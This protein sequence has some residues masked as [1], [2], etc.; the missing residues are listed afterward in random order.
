[1]RKIIECITQIH[2]INI[3]KMCRIKRG[4]YTRTNLLSIIGNIIKSSNFHP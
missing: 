1:M 3:M 2:L 4:I